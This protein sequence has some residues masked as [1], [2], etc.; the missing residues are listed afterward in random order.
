MCIILSIPNY[1]FYPYLLLHDA[2]IF[3]EDDK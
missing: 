2:L 3:Q 1:L